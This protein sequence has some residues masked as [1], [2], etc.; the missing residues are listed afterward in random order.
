MTLVRSMR[1][2]LLTASLVAALIIEVIV[3]ATTMLGTTASSTMNA[4]VDIV[5][6]TTRMVGK[7]SL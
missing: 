6:I 3:T 2:N 5:R 7:V 1:R 4:I